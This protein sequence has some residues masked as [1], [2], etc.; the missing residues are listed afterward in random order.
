[1]KDLLDETLLRLGKRTPLRVVADTVV[2]T[3]ATPAAPADPEPHKQHYTGR[4]ADQ[5]RWMK[6]RA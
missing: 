2:A 1:L 5:I 6:Q 4:K 3:P